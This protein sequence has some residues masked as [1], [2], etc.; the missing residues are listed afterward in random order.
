MSTPIDF[1]EPLNMRFEQPETYILNRHFCGTG[2]AVAGYVPIGVGKVRGRSVG[3][4]FSLESV[5]IAKIDSNYKPTY[6]T[7]C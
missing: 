4:T 6:A 3:K 2:H 7:R 1:D 5:L